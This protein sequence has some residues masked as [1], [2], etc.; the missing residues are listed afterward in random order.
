[1]IYL[2]SLYNMKRRNLY[3]FLFCLI[4][5]FVFAS[6]TKTDS[7]LERDIYTGVPVT[8]V[9]S[10]LSG[11]KL[12][13]DNDIW[14]NPTN[15]SNVQGLK[16]IDRAVIGFSLYDED[17]TLDKL[18]SNSEYDIL[19]VPTYCSELP[20]FVNL[21]DISS[22]EYIE[23]GQDSLIVKNQKI[24]SID[25][26]ESFYVANGY[27]NITG[28]FA[29]S[30]TEP[31]RF[32][33]FYDSKNDLDAVSKKISLNLYYNIGNESSTN[34]VKSSL[35]FKLPN[36]LY[37]LFKEANVS[38]DDFIDFTLNVSTIQN[39]DVKMTTTTKLFDFVQP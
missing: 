25:N 7:G 31:T 16:Y 18:N 5:L 20:T 19:L 22:N 38:D 29:Y 11:Y 17:L 6:C 3:D 14:F 2:F 10:E 33:L 1:M 34:I 39:G 13:T 15:I 12:Y 32:S 37:A 23:N 4:S 28:T 21:I 9:G 24:Q 26:N 30:G 27:V 35:C 8:V 36:E